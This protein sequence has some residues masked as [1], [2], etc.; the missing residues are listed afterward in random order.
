MNFLKKIATVLLVACMTVSL[1]GCGE[2]EVNNTFTP[3]GVYIVDYINSKEYKYII[4]DP[5]VAAQMWQKYST[6]NIIEDETA[7]VDA[8]YLFL[9]FYNEDVSA[10]VI[11]TIYENGTCCLGRDYQTLYKVENGRTAYVELVEIYETSS[12]VVPVEDFVE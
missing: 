12:K 6:L 2:K 11:F 1:I 4:D 5:E 7:Q 8:S 3:A 9:R 10:E